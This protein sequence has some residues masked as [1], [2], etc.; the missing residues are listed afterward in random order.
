MDGFPRGLAGYRPVELLGRGASGLVF[1]A[2]QQGT[3]Q[4][5]AIKTPHV[6]GGPQAQARFQDEV[7]LRSRL[8]HPHIAGLV[9]AGEAALGQPYVVSEWV[10]GQTLRQYLLRHGRLEPALACEL[11]AQLLDALACVH[12]AGVVHRDITPQNLLVCETGTQPNLK[13]IDFGLAAR[14]LLPAGTAAPAGGTPGYCAPEQLRGAPPSPQADLYAWGLVFL[15]CLSGRPALA[16]HGPADLIER[17]LAPEPVALPPQ[18][19]GDALAPLLSEVLAKDPAL[20]PRSAAALH[21]RLRGHLRGAHMAP[22]PPPDS[23]ALPAAPPPG[24]AHA[25]TLL[26]LTVLLT[27]LA[28][29]GLDMALLEGAQLEQ[30]QW[31]MQAIALARGTP[32]RAL[33]DRLLFQFGEPG[34]DGL[35]R[36]ALCLLGL[37]DEAGR[38][39][40]LMQVRHG[41]RL[42]LRAGLHVQAGGPEQGA[43]D[44]NRCAN[45][46]LHL[47]ALAAPGAIL[48]S[49][50]AWQALRHMLRFQAHPGDAA[51]WSLL[52]EPA[53]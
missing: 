27:P 47:N 9:D 34:D 38:R 28:H 15:E 17:Q 24:G 32:S 1:R 43:A 21:A 41:M 46:A 36:A 37:R 44:F 7:R 26:C 52:D 22:P 31:C 13:L 51:A 12:A 35:L 30:Q 53:G 8:Q 49:T 45:M 50:E 16:G 33:G 6:N 42:D 18:L 3:G 40:R 11:M 29:T 23:P 10:P 4:F 20:R 39:S 5:V 14:A 25:L 19:R 48:A 2:W